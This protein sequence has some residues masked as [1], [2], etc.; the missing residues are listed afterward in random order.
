MPSGRPAE[1]TGTTVHSGTHRGSSGGK[2]AAEE[3]QVGGRPPDEHLEISAPGPDDLV[4][5]THDRDDTR[6]GA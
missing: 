5:F 6:K 1:R 2:V 3:R 4:A